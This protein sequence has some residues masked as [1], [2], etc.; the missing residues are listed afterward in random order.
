MAK[1]NDWSVGDRIKLKDCGGKPHNRPPAPKPKGWPSAKPKPCPTPKPT[2]IPIPQPTPGRPTTPPTITTTTLEPTP[3]TY[4]PTAAP[5]PKPTPCGD[6]VC[7]IDEF[8]CTLGCS[9]RCLPIG[10]RCVA[11]C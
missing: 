8:C 4:V 2:P 9:P 7:G 6:A 3:Q 10:R 11:G 5:T 1:A